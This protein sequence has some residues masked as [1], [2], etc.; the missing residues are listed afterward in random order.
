MGM[1]PEKRHWYQYNIGTS[2]ITLIGT[3]TSIMIMVPVIW[4]WYQK[5]EI[6]ISII[7]VPAVSH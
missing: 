2:C 4:E 7:L 3:S 6:G 5:K 1:V